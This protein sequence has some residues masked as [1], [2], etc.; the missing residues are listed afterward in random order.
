MSRPFQH[1]VDYEGDTDE[2]NCNTDESKP[3][4]GNLVIKLD[5]E[6]EYK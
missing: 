4:N 5:K 3:E 1:K 6:E 2:N